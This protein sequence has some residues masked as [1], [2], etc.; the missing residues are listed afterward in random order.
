VTDPRPPSSGSPSVDAE[1]GAPPIGVGR[2]EFHRGLNLLERLNGEVLA[3]ETDGLR[4]TA[5]WIMVSL[6]CWLM[7]I[8]YY[9]ITGNLRGGPRR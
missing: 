9:A 6:A 5:G 7:I 2:V 8:G 1:G 3:R 4:E